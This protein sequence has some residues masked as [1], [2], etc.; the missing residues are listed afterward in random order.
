[1]RSHI[2]FFLFAVLLIFIG[3]E[4]VISV[5]DISDENVTVFSPIDDAQLTNNEVAFSWEAV[6]FSEQYEIQIATPTFENGNE[7]VLDTTIL[8]SLNDRR[9]TKFL[10]SDNYQWRIRAINSNYNTPFIL[11][12]FSVLGDDEED[13]LSNNSI[14]LIAPA[15]NS[16]LDTEIIQF[17]WEALQNASSYAIQIAYPDF[18]NPIQLVVNT[19]TDVPSYETT[20][21]DNQYEWRVQ[22][23]N[24]S[25]ETPYTTRGF[26]VETGDDGTDITSSVVMLLAPSNGVVLT[27]S[28][29]NFSWEAVQNA[30]RYFLQVARPDF[31]NPE[32]FLV[33]TSFENADTR[34][35][36]LPE[37]NYAWRIKAQN[38]SSETSYSSSN[39]EISLGD[40]LSSQEIV[41]IAPSAGTVL[42]QTSINFT[43]ENLPAANE[44]VIQIATPD[45]IN[46]Q[47]IVIDEIS[48][49]SASQ[50]YTLVE[51]SYEWRIKGQNVSSETPFTTNDF[52]VDLDAQLSDQEIVIIS[53]IDGFVTANPS[54]N[55]QWEPLEQA[56]L[57]R[58]II[59]D[60]NSGTVFLEETIN[61]TVLGV[62]FSPGNYEWKVRAENTTQNTPFTSQTI[63]IQ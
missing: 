45:F 20:L 55:L 15:N 48:N 57:Y 7:I 46:P 41:L 30:T 6:D 49:T 39:F 1:M 50:T 43:W 4:E 38:D 13:D 14:T 34:T 58:V 28:E 42:S 24:D 62:N 59:T 19:T 53:P 54:V 5:P 12:S 27:N 37:G 3:C 29:V 60:L 61:A 36:S 63:V 22:G 2:H 8:D 16:Q 33:N 17:S 51:G 23:V 56:T 35:F 40:D 11:N 25:S 18:E 44:Y 31:E 9:F 10:A 47:Q 52:T 21:A 26:I 32:Q